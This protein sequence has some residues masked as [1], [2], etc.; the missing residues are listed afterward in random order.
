MESI[1]FKNDLKSSYSYCFYN[2]LN[3]TSIQVQQD[4]QIIPYGHIPI[5]ESECR[6]FTATDCSPRNIFFYWPEYLRRYRIKCNTGGAITVYGFEEDY[7]SVYIY[8]A[9]WQVKT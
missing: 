1:I 7:Y 8:E 9:T 6:P 5:G 3:F 4:N 2:Q